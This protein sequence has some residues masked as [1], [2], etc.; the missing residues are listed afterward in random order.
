MDGGIRPNTVTRSV[1]IVIHFSPDGSSGQSIQLGWFEIF[2]KRQNGQPYHPDQYIC[3]GS[4]LIRMRFTQMNRTADVSRSVLILA[5]GIYQERPIFGDFKVRAIAGRIMRDGTMRTERHD[6]FKGRPFR[7]ILDFAT[8][9]DFSSKRK[10]RKVIASYKLRE[11]EKVKWS[12]SYILR[13]PNTLPFL[14]NSS[15]LHTWPLH[16]G[17]AP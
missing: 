4:D 6:R 5:T 2:R 13:K 3:V 1:R 7:K 15:E 17:C 16:H 10:L 12:Y 14:P 11:K 8:T 9:V